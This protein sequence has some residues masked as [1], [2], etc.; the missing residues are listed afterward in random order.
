VNHLYLLEKAGVD[1]AVREIFD[2]SLKVGTE[3]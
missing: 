2:G 3:C 1:L